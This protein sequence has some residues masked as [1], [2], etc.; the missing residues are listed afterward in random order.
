[1]QNTLQAERCLKLRVR[2]G[3]G[4]REMKTRGSARQLANE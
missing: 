2:G 1:M 3:E 4:E